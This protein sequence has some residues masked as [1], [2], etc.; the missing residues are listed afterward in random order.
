[1]VDP[2]EDQGHANS[3]RNQRV[4]EGRTVVQETVQ[5]ELFAADHQLKMD[6]FPSHRWV[7]TH[8]GLDE[9]YP[10]L[11]RESLFHDTA[12]DGC[13]WYHCISTDNNDHKILYS[14]KSMDIS[15]ITLTRPSRERYQ[16]VRKHRGV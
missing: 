16:K 4:I 10:I 12:D 11:Q 3:G 14:Y 15:V 1:M 2:Q 5:Q 9:D 6:C 13:V 7:R 8:Q